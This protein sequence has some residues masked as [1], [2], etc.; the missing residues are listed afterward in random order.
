MKQL[1][2][3]IILSSVLS[4][5]SISKK[6][7]SFFVR[8]TARE[9]AIINDG[10]LV[11]A[12]SFK[13]SGDFEKS[14]VLLNE[15]VKSKD[16]PAPAHFEL[17]KIY[18]SKNELEKSLSHINSAV[19]LNPRNKWYLNYKIDLTKK[20]SL[21][22]E[23][24]ETFKLRQ[25]LFPDNSDFDIEFSD[26]YITNKKYLKALK[27]YNMIEKKLGVSHNVNFNKFLIYKGLDDY[28][29]CEGEIKK[30]IKTFPAK[31][32]YYI[33]YADFKIEHGENA[34]A[35]KIY[36]QA[37]EVIPDDSYILNELA[38]YYLKDHKE[39]EA[40]KL[41]EKI[42]KDPTFKISEKR[43]ILRK[44][45]RLSEMDKKFYNYTKILMDLAANTHP[46]ESS[47][48]MISADFLFEGGSY[49]DALVA[50]Q[51]VVEVKP[52]NYNAW[53]QLVICHYNLNNYKEMSEKSEE[54]L[55]LFPAQPS[56]YFYSGM[57]LVQLK[58]Y[59]KAIEVLEEGNDIVL[60]SNKG[61]KAQFLSSLGDA[62]HAINKHEK[63]DEYFELSLEITPENH[64][65]LNNYAYYLS[66][67]NVKLEKARMM[68][69]KSNALNPEEASFQDT[70]GWI[71]YQLGE[72]E[73][74][75]KW[76]KK[77]EIN[78]GSESSIILEHIG[79]VFKK[80]GNLKAAKKYWTKA[81][82]LEG[83]SENLSKKLKD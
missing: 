75:L 5:C 72:Y 45:K 68:S 30:L 76:L 46:Y 81:S 71:L 53:I 14:I 54:G 7:R 69:K 12:I 77:S 26:F 20:L 25:K 67:R 21:Y 73:E 48:N 80:L 51:R 1:I 59:E 56:F 24:E 31:S 52:N 27:L 19:E 17:A 38:S 34:S 61:L 23:C 41:Y 78:G 10:K 18:N 43:H 28:E 64:F 11:D 15:I 58:K 13:N 2:V 40:L 35:L 74:A 82:K 50:Y 63:S 57:A 6:G 55:E 29:E 4:A 47:I 36:E 83:A 70:Y 44:F 9:R 65:V 60:S 8:K 79:D 33:Q 16:D 39:E 32:I 22:P 49:R 42:I 62:Y 3:F 66:E 37:L